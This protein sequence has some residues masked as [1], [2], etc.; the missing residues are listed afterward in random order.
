MSRYRSM[1]LAAL[2]VAALAACGGGDNATPASH[3]AQPKA[4]GSA[5]AS[6][7]PMIPVPSTSTVA[8]P[9]RT[10]RFHTGQA[11]VQ[12]DG[13]TVDGSPLDALSFTA[14]LD[15][16]S[17]ASF[18]PKSGEFQL[19]WVD[20]NGHGLEVDG[21]AP[22]HGDIDAFVR[23]EVD[24]AAFTDSFHTQ[25]ETRLVPTATSVAGQFTCDELPNFAGK[26]SISGATGTFTAAG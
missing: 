9:T 22:R 13:G 17:T 26:G 24:P 19:R 18:N 11:A 25:C 20:Q 14:T 6:A 1:L 12:V 3:S 15:Q 16:D 7:A 10:V 21:T 5:S 2:C 4:Q 8:Y 23:I